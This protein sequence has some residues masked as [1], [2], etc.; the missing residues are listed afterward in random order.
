MLGAVILPIHAQDAP[1]GTFYGTWPYVPLPDHHLNG[2]A[3]NGLDDNLGALFRTYVQLP[4]AIYNWGTEEYV[5]LL[6]E[7]WGFSDDGTYYSITFRSDANWSNG[8]P[9]TSEDVLDTYALGRLN[10]WS[11]FSYI[12]DVVAVDDH[13]VHFMF[14][15]EPSL[16]A[17]RLLLKNYIVDRFT[18][19]DIAQR[20]LAL[21]ATGATRDSAEW[22]ALSTELSEFRP[23]ELIVSGPYTYSLDDVGDAFLTMHWQPNSIFSGSVKFGELRVWAGETEATTP[24][25]LGGQLG[26]TTN[27]YPAS[28]IEQ[29]QAQGLRLLDIARGYGPALLFNHA[30]A[31]WNIKEVRQAIAYAIN[32]EQNAFLTNGIGATATV[33][34]AGLLDDNVP[35]MLTQDAIDQLNHY[36][37]NLE[38]A[39]ALMEQAGFTRN[40]DGKWA[41]A[42]GAVISAEYQFPAEFADFSGAAQD[43]ISQLNDFGFDI[44][45]RAL[46]FA[47]AAANIR[48]GEFQLSV[49]SWASA[50]PFAARQF[51]GPTQR[52]NYVGLSNDQRG[53]DFPMQFEWNGQQV[54][55]NDMINH[56]SDGLDRDVQRERASAVALIINDM[57]PYIPLNI[58]RSIEPLNENLIAGY[59]TEGEWSSNPTN[60]DHAIIYY[61]LTGVISPGPGAL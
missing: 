35:Q 32:R 47:E 18:Y 46:P 20:A 40:A 26:H 5:G 7:S 60:S 49:W 30:Q 34:M 38:T 11:D 58:E 16:V 41:D 56:A 15:G 54:D 37:Y 57:L 19:G 22:Q 17:E 13:T 43:A 4:A 51:F 42:S 24:L 55:L 2:F 9:V 33:Y 6:A 48:A 29:A 36:D 3:S 23:T 59:P 28:T 31:P 39:A 21:F 45:P 27:V 61:L 53:M 12:N 1:T 8:E 10:G 25:L 52:F 50:S 14:S 44:T